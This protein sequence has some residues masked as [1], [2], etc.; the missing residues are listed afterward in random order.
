M[1]SEMMHTSIFRLAITCC[2]LTTAPSDGDFLEL[3][4]LCIIYKTEKQS[5]NMTGLWPNHQAT[6]PPVFV[7]KSRW[8]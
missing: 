1:A 6:R 8:S 5:D 4:R 2:G 7:R 3:V